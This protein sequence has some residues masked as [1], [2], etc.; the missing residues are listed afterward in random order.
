MVDPLL[1]RAE[2]SAQA[3]GNGT[4]NSRAFPTLSEDEEGIDDLS[5]GRY[6]EV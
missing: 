4:V 5:R 2:A 3:A 6:Q 1:S